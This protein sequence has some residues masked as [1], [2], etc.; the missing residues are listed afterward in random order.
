MKFSNE[1]FEYL[2]T[3]H[4]SVHISG[5][6]R[7]LIEFHVALSKKLQDLGLKCW[8]TNRKR[9]NWFKSNNLWSAKYDCYVKTCKNTFDAFIRRRHGESVFVVVQSI[10]VSS[11]TFF[12]K[13]IQCCRGS[14][15]RNLGKELLAYGNS[16]VKVK[17][18]IYNLDKMPK[19]DKITSENVLKQIKFEERHI[20]RYSSDIHRDIEA[21]KLATDEL[22]DG[23]GFVQ[24]ISQNPFGYLIICEFQVIYA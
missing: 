24:E 10:Q 15:R 8:L 12:V 1:E 18:I 20:N 13:K 14:D 22:C 2:E 7:L 3:F 23:F 6:R 5:R 9:F 16:Q 4:T 21:V 19:T 17:N 11:H